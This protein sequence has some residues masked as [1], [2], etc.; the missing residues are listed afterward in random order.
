MEVYVVCTLFQMLLKVSTM[1]PLLGSTSRLVRLDSKES[2]KVSSVLSFDSYCQLMVGENRLEFPLFPFLSNSVAPNVA[3]STRTI[4]DRLAVPSI[5]TELSQVDDF[6]NQ[7]HLEFRHT[8]CLYQISVCYLSKQMFKIQD[9][10]VRFWS[11]QKP[12]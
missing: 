6:A 5:Q 2:M 8:F 4:D 1:V 10:G 7:M 9:V 3:I 12:S 11:I